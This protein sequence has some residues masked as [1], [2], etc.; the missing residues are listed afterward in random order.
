[1]RNNLTYGF[2][3]AIMRTAILERCMAAPCT[4]R[5]FDEGDIAFLYRFF[6]LLRDD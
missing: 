1:M 6:V 2:I 3:C 4:E 5:E